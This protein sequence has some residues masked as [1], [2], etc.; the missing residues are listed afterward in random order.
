MGALKM[1]GVGRGILYSGIVTQ[2]V[3]AA[4]E[5]YIEAA[6]ISGTKATEIRRLFSELRKINLIQPNFFTPENLPQSV[7]KALYP[8]QGSTLLAKSLNALDPRDADAAFRITWPNSAEVTSAG[9]KLLATSSQY[10]DTHF[11]TFTHLN[12]SQQ[13]SYGA[14]LNDEAAISSTAAIM[15]N[16]NSSTSETQLYL[17]GNGGSVVSDAYSAASRLSIVITKPK[18]GYISNSVG[19]GFHKVFKDAVEIGSMVFTPATLPN[20]NVYIG[21]LN[22]R[23]TPQN[24]LTNTIKFGHIAGYITPEAMI[25]F[26]KVV[27]MFLFLSNNN[28]ETFEVTTNEDADFIYNYISLTTV[29]EREG[30]ILGFKDNALY[31]ST[32]NGV[33]YSRRGF[34]NIGTDEINFAYIFQNG[35]ISFATKNK[36]YFSPDNLKTI[37]E[38]TVKDIDGGNL[39][40]TYPGNIFANLMIDKPVY[41]DGNEILIWSNYG[42]TNGNFNESNIFFT[43]DQG[44]SIKVVYKFGQNP[45]YGSYGDPSNASIIRHVHAVDYSPYNNKFYIK[46]GDGEGECKL[47][48][49][50]YNSISDTWAFNL[51]Q[52]S[53]IN[54]IWKMAQHAFVGNNVYWMSDSA[55]LRTLYKTTLA[56]IANQSSFIQLYSNANEPGT[57]LY[58]E[59]D[60][61]LI[62]AITYDNIVYRKIIISKN[63]GQTIIQKTMTMPITNSI[64]IRGTPRNE[65]GFYRFNI[66]TTSLSMKNGTMFIKIK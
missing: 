3:D 13:W 63:F 49:G 27:D 25:Q 29:F 52:S 66:M 44:R 26:H 65:N 64:V 57:C 53:G 10:G 62:G 41:I 19:G 56:D 48:E 9:I 42:N 16:W 43:K 39:N 51:L 17:S 2:A 45:S 4:A 7:L 61:S 5:S 22:N 8:C 12:A 20:Y 46:T 35:N 24:F 18:Y 38:I 36:M 32:D 54:S 23:N 33:T 50:S 47:I 1:S 55:V 40:T 31:L 6:G 21:A 14:Y 28:L 15:S 58:V 30:K 11:N 34:L 59:E 37:T 60:G